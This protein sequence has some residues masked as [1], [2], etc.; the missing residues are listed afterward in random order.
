MV[1]FFVVCFLFVLTFKVSGQEVPLTP[2]LVIDT[3]HCKSDIKQSYA[4]Y[5][6]KSYTIN[7]TWPVIF[8]YD[9]AARG[10]VPL[11]LYS[12]LAEKYQCILVGSNNSRN[13]PLNAAQVSEQAILKDVRTRISIAPNKLFISGFLF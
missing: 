2:G 3:V 10:S 9:P 12:S 11:K 5:L 4:L 6:P 1:R 8:F 7:S 13:G